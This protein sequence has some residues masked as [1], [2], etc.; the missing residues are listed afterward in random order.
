MA[1]KH[2]KT[3]LTSLAIRAM[4]IKTAVIYHYTPITIVKMKNN[5][6]TK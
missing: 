1:N 3:C 2:T 4:Q 6:N 5:D